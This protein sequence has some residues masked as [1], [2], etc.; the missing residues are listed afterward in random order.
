MV[1]VVLYNIVSEMNDRQKLELLN[2]HM[3]YDMMSANHKTDDMGKHIDAIIKA[4]KYC[5][6]HNS[7]YEDYDKTMADA[8]RECEL[9]GREIKQ[10][11]RD[12]KEWGLSFEEYMVLS[13]I[14]FSNIFETVARLREIALKQYQ[15]ANAAKDDVSDAISMMAGTR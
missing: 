10:G 13:S 8:I 11:H 7:K 2:V 12:Y 6:V 3:F 9:I 15:N 1:E 5:R 4:C 14:V